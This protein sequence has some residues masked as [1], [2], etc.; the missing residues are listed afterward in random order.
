MNIGTTIEGRKIYL[1]KL[2]G[3]NKHEYKSHIL[4]EGGMHGREWITVSTA[5]YVITRLVEHHVEYED[6]LKG[7]TW[8]I[9]AVLNPD[10]YEY[11][12][13]TVST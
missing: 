11:S 13:T 1:L 10:G 6:L 5:L 12:L 7:I 9:V 3:G 8:Y 2:T 4:L